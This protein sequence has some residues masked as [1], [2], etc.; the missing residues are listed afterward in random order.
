[1]KVVEHYYGVMKKVTITLD[2]E[3]VHWA[4][5]RA[6]ARRRSLSHLVEEMLREK[7]T[8]EENYQEARR[9]YLSHPPKELKR[10]EETYPQ[11]QELH[12]R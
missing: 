7:M 12:E 2:E 4:R 6:A 10:P 3:V 1:M 9:Q 8:E 5:I 11:R